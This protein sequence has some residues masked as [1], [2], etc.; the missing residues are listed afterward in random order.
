LLIADPRALSPRLGIVPRSGEIL[1]GSRI[2]LNHVNLTRLFLKACF[3]ICFLGASKIS[4][5]ASIKIF[6]AFSLS[7]FL[8]KLNKIEFVKILG[9]LSIV[10]LLLNNSFVNL[11]FVFVFILGPLLPILLLVLYAQ[12]PARVGR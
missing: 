6:P 2:I 5:R 10:D 8:C 1:S 9:F 11:F 3:T 4:R 7:H 12:V